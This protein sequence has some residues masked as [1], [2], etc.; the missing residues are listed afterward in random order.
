MNEYLF[1]Y[2]VIPTNEDIANGSDGPFIWY[3]SIEANS[4]TEAVKEFESHV[5][6]DKDIIQIIVKNRLQ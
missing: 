1:H 3:S 2:Y 4:I 5:A 6:S